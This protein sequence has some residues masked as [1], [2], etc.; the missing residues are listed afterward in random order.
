MAVDVPWRTQDHGAYARNAIPPAE[1]SLLTDEGTPPPHL[2]V[3]SCRRKHLRR[4]VRTEIL[5]LTMEDTEQYEHGKHHHQIE[6]QLRPCDRHPWI[7]GQLHGS[8]SERLQE[9][10]KKQHAQDV[11]ADIRQRHTP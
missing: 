11:E 4:H 2:K 3:L 10:K 7:A 5:H 9:G 1:L 8:Q 6:N